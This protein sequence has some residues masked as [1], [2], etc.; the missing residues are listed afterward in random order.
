MS[1]RGDV[2]FNLLNKITIKLVIFFWVS[3][4]NGSHKSDLLA[5]HVAKL[6]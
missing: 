1:I 2:E 3:G 6:L 5:A 4:K